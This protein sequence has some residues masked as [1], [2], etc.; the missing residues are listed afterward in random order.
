MC[1]K[2]SPEPSRR[3]GVFTPWRRRSFLAYLEI[4]QANCRKKPLAFGGFIIVA[5]DDGDGKLAD[6][7][8]EPTMPWP[9]PSN[10]IRTAWPAAAFRVRITAK[11]CAA[12]ASRVPV[13]YEDETGFHYGVNPGD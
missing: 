8:T 7:G 10:A 12:I 2:I 6:P 9:A 4:M 11:I 1:R 5:C 13:G 3:H